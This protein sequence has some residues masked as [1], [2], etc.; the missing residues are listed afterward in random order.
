M[1]DAFWPMVHERC[2]GPE[3]LGGYVAWI[4][5][6]WNHSLKEGTSEFS[7]SNRRNSGKPRR[8]RYPAI[9]GVRALWMDKFKL[10]FFLGEE[11][12]PAARGGAGRS[13]VPTD[14][15]DAPRSSSD[16]SR[17]LVRDPCRC[18]L[19]PGDASHKFWSH[20]LIFLHLLS[21]PQRRLSGDFTAVILSAFNYFWRISSW[22]RA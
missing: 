20:P 1:N 6:L 21:S 19:R 5:G 16:R 14:P 13:P 3:H 4:P 10:H 18:P 11:A 12:H 22:R 7:R 8:R 17:T 9:S 2:F 15:A